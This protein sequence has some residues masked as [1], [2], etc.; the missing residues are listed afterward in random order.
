MWIFKLCFLKLNKMDKKAKRTVDWIPWWFHSSLQIE[1]LLPAFAGYHTRGQ[2]RKITTDAN[3]PCSCCPLLFILVQIFFF[4]LSCLS[5][6]PPTLPPPQP[7]AGPVVRP[8][9]PDLMSEAACWYQSS[10]QSTSACIIREANPALFR[11]TSV[12]LLLFPLLL[13][14]PACLLYTA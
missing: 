3:F 7:P 5:E 6:C 2:Q 11:G 1:L 4:I 14:S 8:W 10:P 9:G 13:L 12:A